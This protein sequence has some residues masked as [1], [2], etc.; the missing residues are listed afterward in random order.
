MGQAYS[1]DICGQLFRG[2]PDG[3]SMQ[4]IVDVEVEVGGYNATVQ[5]SIPDTD[6]CR[7]CKKKIQRQLADRISMVSKED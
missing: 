3:G 2:S 5:F 4:P 7:K 1:C 6:L